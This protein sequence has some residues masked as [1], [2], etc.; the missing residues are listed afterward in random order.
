MAMWNDVSPIIASRALN[1]LEIF[2]IRDA[3]Q[4]HGFGLIV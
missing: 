3:Y 1:V 2:K 4:I